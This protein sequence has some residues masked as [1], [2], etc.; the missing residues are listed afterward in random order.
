MTLR[1]LAIVFIFSFLSS[2]DQDD[3]AIF[4]IV[5]YETTMN[6]LDPLD[7][8]GRWL[9]NGIKETN[10]L[11]NLEEG[12]EGT[13]TNYLNDLALNPETRCDET[14]NDSFISDLISENYS[15]EA[16]DIVEKAIVRVCS[17]LNYH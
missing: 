2:C 8:G 16:I 6:Q 3:G 5:S 12:Q 1:I 13:I 4:E 10:E 14:A 15:Q 9:A 17:E 7:K 11:N